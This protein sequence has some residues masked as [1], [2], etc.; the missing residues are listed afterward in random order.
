MPQYTNKNT[1]AW[2]RTNKGDAQVNVRSTVNK[3][4]GLEAPRRELDGGGHDARLVSFCVFFVSVL[5]RGCGRR[6]IVEG[7]DT[8]ELQAEVEG[9]V[10]QRP[11]EIHGNS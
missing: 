9:T 2:R 7:A 4:N 10:D 1:D 8:Q 11:D 3:V 6:E 5:A